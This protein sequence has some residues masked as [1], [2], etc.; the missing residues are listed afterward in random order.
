MSE[1]EL[2][3]QEEVKEEVQEEFDIIP[4]GKFTEELDS[5]ID[6]RGNDVSGLFKDLIN[7]ELFI[8]GLEFDTKGYIKKVVLCVDLNSDNNLVISGDNL[9]KI[10]LKNLDVCLG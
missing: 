1:L 2:E 6:T 4:L 3:V 7:N 5:Y 10:E 8:K 9:N